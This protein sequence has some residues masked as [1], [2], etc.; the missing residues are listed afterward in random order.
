MSKPKDI[1]EDIHEMLARLKRLQEKMAQA[2]PTAEEDIFK[3]IR[4]IEK[5]EPQWTDREWVVRENTHAFLLAL[6]KRGIREQRREAYRGR[7][8]SIVA[9]LEHPFVATMVLSQILEM[10]T[11]EAKVIALLDEAVIVGVAGINRDT[12]Q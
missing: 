1:P 10:A 11:T 12:Q 2:D 4:Q 5:D 7:I 9:T 3:A 6:E 8:E